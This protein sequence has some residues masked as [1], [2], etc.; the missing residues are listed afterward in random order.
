MVNNKRLNVMVAQYFANGGKVTK[1]VPQAAV[2]FNNPFILTLN[3][4][5]I[6]TT[7]KVF[8]SYKPV[9][10]YTPWRGCW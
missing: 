1:C 8:A 7:A 3:G 10:G 9:I 4:K 5:V 2:V 6:S